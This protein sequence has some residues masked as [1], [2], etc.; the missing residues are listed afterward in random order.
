MRFDHIAI[1]AADL[2]SGVDHVEAALGVPLLPGGT[3]P[4]Y[5]THNRV[6]GLGEGL[7]LE[8][9][10]IDPEAPPPEE[11]RWF[12]LDRFT[13]PPRL[14]NWICS[15]PDLDRAV[16][17]APVDCGSPR[18]LARGDLTWRIAVP[19]DGSL[20][21]GGAFPTLIEWGDGVTSPADSL[22]DSGVRLTGWEVHLQQPRRLA[23][24]LPLA[25]ARVTFHKDRAA[26][27]P[28]FVARFDTPNGPVVLR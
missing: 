17:E 4:R 25:D 2:Q 14:A 13:G 15:V 24:S 28:H 7:Y 21:I 12:D 20:P 9:I 11:P 10:A 5:G 3:H 16:A 1:A 27:T 8:V 22:P 19:D 23:A 6:L 18:D 26:V